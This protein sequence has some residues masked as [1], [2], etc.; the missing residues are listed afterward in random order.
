MRGSDICLWGKSLCIYVCLYS[1]CL[2]LL[3]NGWTT[4]RMQ[5]EGRKQ[6]STHK[7]CVLGESLNMV[8]PFLFLTFYTLTCHECLLFCTNVPRQIIR[9]NIYGN[10][11]I[12]NLS[13][14]LSLFFS[15][16]PSM[17]TVVQAFFLLFSPC[18]S[19]Y[20]EVSAA[21]D[22]MS[23][24]YTFKHWYTVHQVWLELNNHCY[25]KYLNLYINIIEKDLLITSLCYKTTYCQ[26]KRGT[27]FTSSS[28]LMSI[29]VSLTYTHILIYS[30]THLHP[31]VFQRQN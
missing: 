21:K 31:L 6:T 25:R 11:T 29:E 4:G 20:R 5:T 18:G 9:T 15:F 26:L 12:W 13:C 30:L 17:D 24:T 19:V 14:S 1:V 8:L 16:F 7:K 3:L 27:N 2:W 22:E 10:K 28:S 23:G